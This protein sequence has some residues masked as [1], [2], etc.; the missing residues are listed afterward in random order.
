MTEEPTESEQKNYISCLAWVRRGVS[1]SVPDK[2][3]I[4]DDFCKLFLIDINN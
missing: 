1:A 3:R 2:V 4:L